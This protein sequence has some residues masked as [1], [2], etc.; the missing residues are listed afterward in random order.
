MLY[1]Q[2]AIAGDEQGVPLGVVRVAGDLVDGLG[3]NDRCPSG[4][5]GMNEP[6]APSKEASG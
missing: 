2:H 1:L 5:I 3:E 4:A 6:G